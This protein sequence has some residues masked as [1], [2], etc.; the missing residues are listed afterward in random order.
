MTLGRTGQ[1]TIGWRRHGWALKM[2][3]SEQQLTTRDSGIQNATNAQTILDFSTA[4]RT[5]STLAARMWLPKKSNDFLIMFIFNIFSLNISKTL[6]ETIFDL[7]KHLPNWK[8]NAGHTTGAKPKRNKNGKKKHGKKKH[9]RKGKHVYV[10]LFL[11]HSLPLDNFVPSKFHWWYDTSMIWIAGHC[12]FL[13]RV[14]SL[15]PL[16]NSCFWIWFQEIL[17]IDSHFDMFSFF[18]FLFFLVFL[19]LFVSCSLI[20]FIVSG[21]FRFFSMFLHFFPFFHVVFHLL[22]FSVGFLGRFIFSFIFIVF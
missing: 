7:K 4:H 3:W 12:S 21:V 11:D 18:F 5:R 15:S 17:Y 20:S 19:D 22:Y 13:P 8:P 6:K 9:R 10:L 16:C 2:K 14:P 1:R